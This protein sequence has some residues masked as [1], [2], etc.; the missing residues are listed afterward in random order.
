MNLLTTKVQTIKNSHFQP[1]YARRST[2]ATTNIIA[3]ILSWM[4][5]VAIAEAASSADSQ[6]KRSNFMI[7]LNDSKIRI[8]LLESKKIY[9]V[10]LD[11]MPSFF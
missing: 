4:L 8:N 10:V 3:A 5:A 11:F 7:K 6:R 2:T 9:T 1:T